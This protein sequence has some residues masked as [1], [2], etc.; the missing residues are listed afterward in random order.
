MFL[1]I[2]PGVATTVTAQSAVSK[3]ARLSVKQVINAIRHSLEV[4]EDLDS[5]FG[6][7]LWQGERAV[8]KTE[9]DGSLVIRIRKQ[10]FRVRVVQE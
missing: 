10:T 3:M 6:T 9:N 5:G 8:L 2:F 7:R 4:V 1:P